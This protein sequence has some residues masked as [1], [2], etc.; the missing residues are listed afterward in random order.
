ME[1]TQ[2]TFM[3]R[4]THLKKPIGLKRRALSVVLKIKNLLVCEKGS[5]L[6]PHPR[7]GHCN[8]YLHPCQTGGHGAPIDLRSIT[9]PLHLTLFKGE[10]LNK[11]I[12]DLCSSIHRG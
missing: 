12:T 5:N 1:Y 8:D 6:K 11:F 3:G 10:G 7:V 9:V 4:V 2:T